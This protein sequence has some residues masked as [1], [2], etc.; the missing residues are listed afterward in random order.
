MNSKM[1]FNIF[2][3]VIAVI[4]ILVAYIMNSDPFSY[5]MIVLLII[6]CLVNVFMDMDKTILFIGFKPGSNE[7]C[8]ACEGRI[9]VIK[10]NGITIK[11]IKLDGFK[12]TFN[13]DQFISKKY[14][15]GGFKRMVYFGMTNGIDV[16]PFKDIKILMEETIQ[17]PT[18]EME[19]Y[20]TGELTKDGAGN[21]I[22]VIA[23]RPIM[24]TIN[25]L[26]NN[27]IYFI[28][29]KLLAHNFQKLKAVSKTARPQSNLIAG[30]SIGVMAVI[31]L[32]TIVLIYNGGKLDFI[33]NKLD[34]LK[35]FADRIDVFLD[36]G[37]YT[38]NS[39]GNAVNNT[40][41]DINGI[42][43]NQ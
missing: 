24:K 41:I 27:I 2:A 28:N 10:D 37:Y 13:E 20:E 30:L 19:E 18:G 25:I 12:D 3:V 43:L 42:N 17:Q 33:A 23:Q 29:N 40:N 22:P 38:I 15:I 6:A 1:I 36:R 35:T 8:L 4:L 31:L 7:I 26:T 16:S 11:K 39:V 9:L 5:I 34:F 14:N 32:C 21:T